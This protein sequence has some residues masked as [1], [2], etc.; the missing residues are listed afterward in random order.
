MDYGDEQ[1]TIR[2]LRLGGWKV[3]SSQYESLLVISCFT[4]VGRLKPSQFLEDYLKQPISMAL[5]EEAVLRLS[6]E[7]AAVYREI[8]VPKLG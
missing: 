5:R 6:A 4:Y 8:L 1:L 3:A 2:F 7:S